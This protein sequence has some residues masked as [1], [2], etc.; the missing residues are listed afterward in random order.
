[1]GSNMEEKVILHGESKV[2]FFLC[3]SLKILFL[4]LL[5]LKKF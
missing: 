3:N 5:I 4:H 1:M 2:F